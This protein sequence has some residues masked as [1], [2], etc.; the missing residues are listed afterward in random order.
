MSGKRPGFTNPVSQAKYD[1]W[2][3]VK[4]I[5]KEQAMQAYI[6]LVERLNSGR[7]ATPDSPYKPCGKL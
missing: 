4:G 7:G 5:S 6:D 2:K 3:K 1:A